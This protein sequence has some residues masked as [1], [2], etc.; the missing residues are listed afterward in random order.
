[1][2]VKCPIC[3]SEY[4]CTPGKYQCDCGVKFYVAADGSTSTE[5]PTM[6]TANDSQIILRKAPSTETERKFVS[7]CPYCG[8]AYQGT[9]DGIG[10]VTSCANC[11]KQI[12]IQRDDGNAAAPEPEQKF[13]SRCPYCGGA[14]QGTEGEIGQITSCVNCGKQIIIQ[15]DDSNATLKNAS[16]PD[17]K[18]AS[19]CPYCGNPYF[20]KESEIGQVMRCT[21]CGKQIVIQRENGNQTNNMGTSSSYFSSGAERIAPSSNGE[22]LNEF[23]VVMLA[24]PIIPAIIGLLI[25]V[26]IPWWGYALYNTV[27]VVWDMK[28]LSKAGY[29]DKKFLWIFGFTLIPLYLGIRAHLTKRWRWFVLWILS[30]FT[31]FAIGFIIGILEEIAKVAQ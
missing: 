23:P 13:V 18:F 12:I 5:K 11:G 22:K 7:R 9:E 21:N 29:S 25:G 4:D 17:K 2:I 26:E 1:M 16:A 19:N 6:G 27:F 8:N 24:L 28:I 15:R 3:K 30:S 14:Y 10:Q 31:L 20:A